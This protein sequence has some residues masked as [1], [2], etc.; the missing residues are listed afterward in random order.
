[1]L[2]PLRPPAST[3][4]NRRVPTKIALRDLGYFDT[5]SVRITQYFD[6]TMFRD[7]RILGRSDR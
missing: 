3:S 5:P 1:M 6:E 2:A 7:R 4:V